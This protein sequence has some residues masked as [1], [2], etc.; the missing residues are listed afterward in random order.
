MIW[1]GVSASRRAPPFTKM[2]RPSATKAL[3]ERSLMMTT[4]IFCCVRPATRRIG[5][6]YS[7]SNCSISASR[8]IGGPLCACAG[9]LAPTSALAVTTATTRAAGV[10][11]RVLI[12]LSDP[13]MSAGLDGIFPR[14]LVVAPNMSTRPG[15]RILREFDNRKCSHKCGD[16]GAEFT[17]YQRAKYSVG[18]SSTA[19]HA[20]SAQQCP[21]LYGDGRDGGGRAHRRGGRPRHPYGGRAACG[22]GADK[23]YRC[24][25]RRAGLGS[26]RLHRDARHCAAART[27]CATL[28]RDLWHRRRS[29]ACRGYHGLIG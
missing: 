23:R 16:S 6:V 12:G 29:A 3:N 2:G 10:V 17:P 9:R 14:N 28:S 21:C 15:S 22:T 11:P 20:L 13:V 24:G 25:A 26:S 4:W 8:M 19:Y 5:W 18:C 27:H 7:L 1:L